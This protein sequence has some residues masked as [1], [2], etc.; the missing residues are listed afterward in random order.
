MPLGDLLNSNSAGF[1]AGFDFGDDFWS[2]GLLSSGQV[3]GRTS[4]ALAGVGFELDVKKMKRGTIAAQRQTVASASEPGE[5]L[6]SPLGTWS[7]QQYDWSFGEGQVFFDRSDSDRRRGHQIRGGEWTSKDSFTVGNRFEQQEN[8]T[9]AGQFMMKAGT[10][11]YWYNG[12]T[13]R[14]TQTP[15]LAAASWTAATTFTG[16]PLAITNDGTKVYLATT[17][18]LFSAAIGTAAIAATAIVTRV[19]NV[20]YVQSHLIVDQAN[21][22]SEANAAFALTTITTHP[23]T[24]FLWSVIAGGNGFIYAGGSINGIS[25]L[26]VLTVNQTTGNLQRASSAATFLPDEIIYTLIVYAQKAILGTSAG[27]RVGDIVT[28]GGVNYGPAIPTGACKALYGYGSYVYFGATAIDG[29]TS[30]LGKIDLSV[31]VN[32]DTHQF[33]YAVDALPAVAAGQST[34]AVLSLAVASTG[35][36]FGILDQKGI[37]R[38]IANGTAAQFT[39]GVAIYETGWLTFNT[40]ERKTMTDI[41]AGL[42][43]P[44][45]FD[46]CL[47]EY[48]TDGS[49]WVAIGTWAQG[50]LGPWALTTLPQPRRVKFRFTLTAGVG[51]TNTVPF[52]YLSYWSVR[53]IPA[54]RRSRQYVLPLI[55]TEQTDIGWGAGALGGYPDVQA[56]YEYMFNYVNSGELVIYQEGVNSFVVKIEDLDQEVWQWSDNAHGFEG[57]LYATVTVP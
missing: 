49:T 3:P 37:Y 32:P 26:Y 46:T 9:V 56:V 38:K 53:I 2:G 48:S 1:G 52:P 14:L 50:L 41:D 8:V 25:E 24:S 10:W 19:D 40:I 18:G 54:P 55:V 15:T 57:L 23:S 13:L 47:V 42:S 29:V 12:T 30:G 20:A 33:A 36:V 35:D 45:S 16:T 17:T 11:W 7:R 39:S 31:A 27:V 6:L 28:L 34:N 44:T 43:L 4:V 22:L 51:R 5:Q 21:V